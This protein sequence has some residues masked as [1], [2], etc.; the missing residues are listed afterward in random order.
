MAYVPYGFV[1]A[2]VRSA[3]AEANPISP[4]LLDGSGW[5]PLLSEGASVAY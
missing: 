4:L 2:L 5:L 3:A 1:L